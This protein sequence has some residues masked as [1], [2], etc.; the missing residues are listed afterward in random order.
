[1]DE[2]EGKD[3][4]TTT[5]PAEP[6]P[7]DLSDLKQVVSL[8]RNCQRVEDIAST[9]KDHIRKLVLANELDRYHVLMLY[10]PHGRI[11]DGTANRL[12]NAMP[13]GKSELLLVLESP[14]GSVEPA[15]LLSKC[16]KEYSTKLVVIVPRK[17]KSA[18]TLIALGADEIHMGVLSQLGPID[19]QF[20]GLPALGLSSAIEHL[21]R[22]CKKYPESSTMFAKY[23]S[24]KLDLRTL[25]YFERVSESATQ[26]AQRLLQGKRL[27]EG[28]SPSKVANQFVYGYKDHGFVIDKDEAKEFLGDH[29]KSATREYDLGNE[30]HNFLD[31]LGVVASFFKNKKISY[32][33]DIEKG[34]T[35]SDIADEE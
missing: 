10:D 17:A 31:F 32:V 25:G 15:Y 3:K 7:V 20:E 6:Q 30:I 2:S 12:Y 27:P 22:L 24:N 4:E 29:I 28:K 26:Y 8:V 13:S 33:G 11:D 14:G 5:E 19:P 23:L 21:A 9:V 1:M 16:C 34:L 35:F 18:A